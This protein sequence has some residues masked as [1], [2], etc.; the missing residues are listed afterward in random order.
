MKSSFVHTV[1]SL[2]KA[3]LMFVST[4]MSTELNGSFVWRLISAVFSQVFSFHLCY[5]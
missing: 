5:W 1:G 4:K 2:Y 3:K